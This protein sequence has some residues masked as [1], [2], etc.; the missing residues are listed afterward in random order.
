MLIGSCYVNST[1]TIKLNVKLPITWQIFTFLKGLFICK[2]SVFGR[3][4]SPTAQSYTS[5]IITIKSNFTRVQIKLTNLLALR[6]T[7]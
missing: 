1:L 3:P 7:L 4:T 2:L 6:L 5:K